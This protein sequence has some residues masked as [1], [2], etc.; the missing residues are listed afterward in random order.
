MHTYL[1]LPENILGK[2]RNCSR[3]QRVHSTSRS[4]AA[5]E[6]AIEAA[7]A[8]RKP[9]FARVMRRIHSVALLA[10]VSASAFVSGSA[11]A[12]PSTSANNANFSQTTAGAITQTVPD[13]VC[14]I[15]VNIRGGSG[16]SSGTTAALGGYGAG[17]ANINARFNVLSGQAVTGAVAGGGN[18]GNIAGNPANNGQ[19]GTGTAAG[20]NGGVINSTTI[21]RGGGGGG[22]SSI[23]VGGVKMVEAGGGG[24]G[25]AAH[26]AAPL[27]NGG[28]GGFSGIAPGVV[29]VGTTGN[30]GNN[31][32]NNGGQ[33]GLAAAGGAGGVQTIDTSDGFAG[34]GIGTGTGGN[35]G[36]D[37]GTDS[38]GGGGGG[39]TGGGGGSGTNAD[40]STGAG[41]GG[42]S[43][44]V[45]GTSP[46][47]S[48]TTPTA[49]SGSAGTTTAAG[50]VVGAVGAATIDWI[51]C[52][53]ALNIGKTASVST[54]NAGAKTIWTVA[55]RNDGPDPMTK[56][57]VVTLTDTLPTGPIGAPS[58]QFRVL[59][60]G[61][62]GGS[63][64]DMASGAVTC[65]GLTVGSAMPA[66]T[67]CSRP[68]SAPTAPGAPSGGT[69]GLN[70]GETLTITYEQ[71][72]ANTAAAASITNTATVND[73]STLIGTTDIT[74]TNV[75]RTASATVNVVPYNLRVSKTASSANINAGGDITWTVVVTN[76]GPGNMFG[77]DDTTANA[78]SVSDVAPI[79]NAGAPSA[80]TSSGSAGSCTYTAGTITCPGSLDNGQA[81]TFT[82]QQTVNAG[83]SAGTLIANTAS[84]TDYVTGD[85]NDSG[86]ASVTVSPSA[87]LS[88]LK[89]NGVSSVVSG[90]TI[91]YSL[92]AT[93]NGPDSTTG[94]IVTDLPG[95]GITC[96]AGNLV[97]ITGSGVPAGSF[98]VANLTGAGI[99]LATLANG[100]S[101]TLTYSCQVN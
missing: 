69:R 54:V 99:T 55:V 70:N 93:N 23:S 97:T 67:V 82:F 78:L 48:A 80:F 53:Y 47:V 83:T 12:N 71:V 17:G 72:F 33:G 26:Q 84:A 81:Q 51:P 88:I 86:S 37:L 66:S 10:G 25:G 9:S 14:A 39:Y 96:P 27:G 89:S 3:G 59:S 52:Q 6:Q 75:A 35:G 16:A 40:S 42:G 100:Q 63:N 20:G 46:T 19:G 65:T 1:E 45:R 74:G 76:D 85:S 68:Y 90:S 79:V 32:T 11:S 28:G 94:A 62:S 57:D 34:G 60:I 8:E 29:A 24:G 7:T 87:N 31:V 73:R 43:S 21:H 44:F 4:R 64:A 22:S 38:G 101:A 49:V 95:T 50:A 15:A 56:G 61:T 13:G 36:V 92:L 91:T 30:I 58:P 18:F 98:T 41:G 2:N 77:P 5:S